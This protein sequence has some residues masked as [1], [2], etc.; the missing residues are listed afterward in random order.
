MCNCAGIRLVELNKIVYSQDMTTTVSVSPTGQVELPESFRKR[1][2]IK[3]GMALRITE[4]G[5]G[6][7]VTPLPEPTEEELR[8]VI[9]AA[10][11]LT[12]GQASK[13]EQMV[14]DVIAE[15]R[16]RKRRKR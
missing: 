5:D 3:P 13:D 2:K 7:Y 4:V 8:K 16:A 11:S 12:N 6:L 1:K 15:Y 14:H 10:G 9:V